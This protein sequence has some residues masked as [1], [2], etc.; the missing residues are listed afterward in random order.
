MYS[1]FKVLENGYIR[2]YFLSINTDDAACKL[3]S[4]HGGVS[5]CLTKMRNSPAAEI[6]THTWS[7]IFAP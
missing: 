3:F 2:V 4:F 5:F 1:E 7:N 6:T